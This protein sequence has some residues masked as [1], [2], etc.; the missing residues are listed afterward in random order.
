MVVSLGFCKSSFSQNWLNG[1]HWD[2][3]SIVNIPPPKLYGYSHAGSSKVIGDTLINSKK[4][5]IIESSLNTWDYLHLDGDKIYYW[6]QNEVL[7]FFELNKQAGDSFLI[8]L[9]ARMQFR[10]RDTVIKDVW[11]KI[12]TVGHLFRLDPNSPVTYSFS[13]LSN[14]IDSIMQVGTPYQV[15][16][17]I[18]IPMIRTNLLTYYDLSL[19]VL[20]D[21]YVN[22]GGYSKLKISCYGNDSLQSIY[23]DSAIEE[24]GLPCDL[25]TGIFQ[26][27]IESKAKIWPNPF[28]GY[29]MIEVQKSLNA[30]KYFIVN[31][32]GEELTFGNLETG[33]NSIEIPNSENII[34]LKIYDKDRLIVRIEKLVRSIE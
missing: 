31:M 20:F 4:F 32:L 12:D 19:T 21:P 18:T 16:T 11:V 5:Y 24:E 9:H 7:R 25:N 14:S 30:S 23:K 3:H 28:T 22:M 13:I 26:Q 1:S 33:V 15:P 10:N 27:T 2:F 34:I 29:V 6:K 8:D 17:A